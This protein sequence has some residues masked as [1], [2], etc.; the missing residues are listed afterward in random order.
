MYA[1]KGG[2]HELTQ[3]RALSV[4]ALLF[5]LKLTKGTDSSW[6]S[7]I[8]RE[9]PLAVLRFSELQQLENTHFSRACLIAPSRMYEV[10]VFW[11]DISKL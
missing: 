10:C 5:A 6:V 7:F 3:T 9:K 4:S 1:G 8:P 2:E 11:G